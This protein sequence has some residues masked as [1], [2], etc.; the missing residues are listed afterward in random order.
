MAKSGISE[1]CK[2]KRVKGMEE[3]NVIERQGTLR[4][5]IMNF[6]EQMWDEEKSV[7]VA[8]EASHTK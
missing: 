8:R 2:F 6:K 3:S 4:G 7:E 5:T 1:L